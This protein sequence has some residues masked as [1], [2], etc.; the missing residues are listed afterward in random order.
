MSNIFVLEAE[1]LLSLLPTSAAAD[2]DEGYG[3]GQWGTGQ[4]GV[5]N[6]ESG[7]ISMV[8]IGRHIARH[9]RTSFQVTF[10]EFPFHPQEV[11]TSYHTST[12]LSHIERP[13][14]SMCPNIEMNGQEASACGRM[15]NPSRAQGTRQCGVLN[16]M[17]QPTKS[18]LCT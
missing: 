1:P 3:R 17:S 8:T 12:P 4:R 10:A 2:R 6:I 18:R 13:A 11:T 9:K 7:G 15:M 5:W 14:G 16:Q